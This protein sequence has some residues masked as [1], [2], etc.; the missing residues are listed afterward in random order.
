VIVYRRMG[1]VFGEVFYE[2]VAASAPKVDVLRISASDVLPNAASRARQS[3]TLV[4][5]LRRAEQ[6]L[7]DEMDK[8]TRYQVHRAIDRDNF[9]F[10]LDD[11]CSEQ[12]IGLFCDYYDRFAASKNRRPIFQKRLALLARRGMLVLTQSRAGDGEILVWHSYIRCAD[13]V[14][15]LNSASLF[16]EK[17][18]TSLRN[19]IGRANRF[20][21][22][23][24]ILAFK[25][26][27]M[28]TY[29]MGGIDVAGRSRE[30][31]NIADFKRGFGGSVVP[32]YSHTLPVSMAGRV[33]CGIAG[34]LS[35]N[36]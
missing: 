32:V 12:D 23:N 15:L 31:S 9:D 7:F 25:R 10:G 22:W 36:L 6:T 30:T 13:R 24:D 27:G 35:V 17:S 18:D 26:M 34:I 14:I 1:L 8:G 33:A 21:H 28:I 19:L 3:H 11:E 20:T 2:P 16:R 4:I 5:D 29:D